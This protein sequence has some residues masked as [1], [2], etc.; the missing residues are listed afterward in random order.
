MTARL[1][2]TPYRRSCLSFD[3]QRQRRSGNNK[4]SCWI[5]RNLLV[6]FPLL[7]TLFRRSWRGL[8][9]E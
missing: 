8:P 6:V 1:A 9:A 4:G 2:L 7:E 5:A 3:N